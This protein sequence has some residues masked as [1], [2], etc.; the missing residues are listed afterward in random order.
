MGFQY[1]K[2]VK[3]YAFYLCTYEPTFGRHYI[4]RISCS[5][6]QSGCHD[7]TGPMPDT[8]EHITVIQAE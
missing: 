8:I 6:V 7:I 3:E 5:Q 4:R 2:Y 1:V